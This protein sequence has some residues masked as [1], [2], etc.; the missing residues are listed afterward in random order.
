V[1]ALDAWRAVVTLPH[2]VG[3]EYR[4]KMEPVPFTIFQNPEGGWILPPSMILL[5]FSLING[6]VRR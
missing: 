1:K 6:L 4:A 5:S 3:R 2:T